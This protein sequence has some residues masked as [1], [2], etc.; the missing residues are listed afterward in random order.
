[1]RDQAQPLIVC[2]T[3][4]ERDNIALLVKRIMSCTPQAALLFVDDRGDDGT[5][6]EIMRQQ[7]CHKNI[8]LLAQP[9]QSGLAKAYL[10]GFAWGLARD[11]DYFVTMDAD[12]S[13]DPTYLQPLLRLLDDCDV[14]IGSRY[15]AGGGTSDW[16]L[17][18]RWLS[19]FGSFYA[20][21]LLNLKV[22]DP[23]S[24]FVA[25]RRRALEELTLAEVKSRGYVFQVELKHRAALAGCMMR[26]APIV[27][28]DRKQGKSKM[29]LAI[30]FEAALYTWRLR[31]LGCRQRQSTPKLL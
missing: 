2:P 18:R 25:F 8:F 6:A 10:A 11:F 1:M 19:R 12:L 23:T 5:A 9:Q 3:Y 21:T 17:L 24:G 16:S 28:A 7:Q 26:E 14:A 29:T 13:H 22:H 31:R 27:F 15:I 20:R 4:N 30:A